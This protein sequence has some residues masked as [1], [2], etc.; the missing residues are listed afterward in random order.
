MNIDSKVK[1][2]EVVLDTK[3]N[4]IHVIFENSMLEDLKINKEKFYEHMNSDKNLEL[5]IR[6]ICKTLISSELNTDC[7]N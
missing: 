3:T 7:I 6:N 2:F 1:L 4:G 5:E